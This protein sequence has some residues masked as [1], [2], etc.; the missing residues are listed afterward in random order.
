MIRSIQIQ[1][2][3]NPIIIIIILILWVVLCSPSTCWCFTHRIA[4]SH[5]PSEAGRAGSPGLV[6]RAL[7][8]VCSSPTGPG[9]RVYPGTAQGLIPPLR[10]AS[11]RMRCIGA[12][13]AGDV[14]RAQSNPI[15][16]LAL[17]YILGPFA[18]LPVSSSVIQ[19]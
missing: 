1:F 4:Y 17:A 2:Q 14:A 6:D 15:P 5:G 13:G 12:V 7:G 19:V 8:R 10:P 3:S 9:A 16:Q 11:P 18:I